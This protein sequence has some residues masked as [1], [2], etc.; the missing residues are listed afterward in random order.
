MCFFYNYFWL[1]RVPSVSE[2]CRIAC[3]FLLFSR[4]YAPCV[5]RSHFPTTFVNKK[6]L[7]FWQMRTMHPKVNASVR[8]SEAH[9]LVIKTNW[10]QVPFEK[11]LVF[12]FISLLIL[13][14]KTLYFRL[15]RSCSQIAS[16]WTALNNIQGDF[17]KGIPGL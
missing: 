15:P 10:L 2:T 11:I 6:L 12:S 17:S 14:I 16:N 7:L 5:I 8:N 13:L 3:F 9:N 1:Y 4:I